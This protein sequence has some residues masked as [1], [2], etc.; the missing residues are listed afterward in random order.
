MLVRKVGQ[1]LDHL[2][3][4]ESSAAE[5]AE[6][7]GEPRSS[8]YR[9]LASL[10]AEGF[11]E[12]GSRRGRYRLGFKLLALGTAV[13]ARFDERQVAL[14]AMERLHDATGETVFLCVPRRDEA[15]CI[16]RLDGKRV[17]SLALRLGGSLPLHAGAASRALL[18]FR[19]EAEWEAYLERNAPLSR[20][21]PST[22]DT[23]A[24]LRALLRRTRADGYA[25]SDQDVTVGV[26]AVG[27]PILDYRGEVRAA[28]SFSG[29]R[30]SILG[31]DFE[32]WRDLLLEAGREVSRALGAELAGQGI[33][34]FG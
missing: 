27:V 16:E 22:P 28:L 23:P 24:A 13:V 5:I 15:V 9:L 26:A 30:E 10:Q 34:N 25:L 14:P 32:Q 21:T 29:V 2:A 20:F 17:Q 6:A 18:A 12:P 31:P 1:L 11:V 4:G 33:A 3:E 8:V 19:P 7:I